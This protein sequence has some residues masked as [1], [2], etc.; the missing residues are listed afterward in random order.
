M[1]TRLQWVKLY[2]DLETDPKMTVIARVTGIRRGNIIAMMVQCFFFAARNEERG[3][4]SNW[5]MEQA[6]VTLEYEIEEMETILAQFR[7]RNVIDEDDYLVN[8]DKYQKSKFDNSTPRVQKLRAKRAE[9]TNEA[10][11][12]PKKP[13]KQKLTDQDTADDFAKF[14]EVYPSR[15]GKSNPRAEAHKIFTKHRNDKFT[16]EDMIEGAAKFREERDHE[17]S[18]QGQ[19]AAQYTPMAKTWLNQRQWIDML[20]ADQSGTSHTGAEEV[21]EFSKALDKWHDDGAVGRKPQRED[22]ASEPPETD[23]GGPP[24]APA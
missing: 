9:E 5:D 13:G 10:G 1:A 7:L 16:S 2:L 15:G 24:A 3:S 17:I 18:V 21:G 11:G 6:Q 4:L 8:W 14:W 20:P 19:D 22:Y 12:K 23:P